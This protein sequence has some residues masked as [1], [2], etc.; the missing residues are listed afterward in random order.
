VFLRADDLLVTFLFLIG[1]HKVV[2]L[3]VKGVGEDIIIFDLA[4]KVK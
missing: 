3:V 4:R 1:N 2:G